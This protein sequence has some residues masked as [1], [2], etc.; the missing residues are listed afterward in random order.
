[1]RRDGATVCRIGTH[2][3]DGVKRCRLSACAK[4]MRTLFRCQ[5]IS[6]FDSKVP[7]VDY[8]KTSKHDRFMYGIILSVN[9]HGKEL[10]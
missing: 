1:M 5:A 10:L 2:D 3:K 7:H 4:Y 8:S 6:K 9:G